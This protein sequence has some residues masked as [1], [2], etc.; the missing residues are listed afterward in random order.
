MKR[1]SLIHG[2]R[3]MGIGA[4][5]SA[6]ALLAE[7]LTLD[8][9]NGTVQTSAMITPQTSAVFNGSTVSVGEV[10]EGIQEYLVHGDFDVLNGDLVT[11]TS[12]GLGVRFRVANDV[13]IAPGGLLDFSADGPDGGPGGGD[14]S[15]GGS[16]GDGSPFILNGGDSATGGALDAASGGRAGSGRL[17]A[18]TPDGGEGDEGAA[19]AWGNAGGQG[20]V[21]FA[22]GNSHEGGFGMNAS[23]VT[24]G[25]QGGSGG[26]GGQ[27]TAII[28]APSNGG[29]GGAGG[30]GG[31]GNPLAAVGG[32]G[33]ERG[34]DGDD[35]N[36][37]SQGDLG[38]GGRPGNP[39][40]PG[41]HHYDAK[42]RF[43]LV[44]GSA[45]SGGGGGGQGGQGGGGSSGSGGSAG[46]GGGGGG[47][48]E[49][50]SLNNLHGVNGG[51]GGDG[52]QGGASGAGGHGGEGGAGGRGGVGGGGGGVIE[53]IAMGSIVID[54]DI[55]AGGGA[56]TLGEDGEG[57]HAGDPGE[58][59]QAG[60][61]GTNG[62]DGADVSPSV[63]GGGQS[64]DGHG[65][66]GDNGPSIGRG[67]GGGGGN[68]GNG[69][70]GGDGGRGGSGGKGG[71]GGSGAG[72]AG[73]T[74]SL[75]AAQVS[76]SG[77]LNTSGGSGG[78]HD[79]ALRGGAG[80]Q[81]I[82]SHTSPSQTPN[83]MGSAHSLTTAGPLVANRFLYGST[84]ETPSIPNLDGGADG[85]GLAPHV[86]I[87]ES[88]LE[89]LASGSDAAVIIRLNSTSPVASGLTLD[90]PG[91]DWVLFHNPTDA[92]IVDPEMGFDGAPSK[93]YALHLGG[94][95]NNPDFG[96]SNRPEVLE[97]LEPGAVYL[98][99][100]P[101]SVTSIAYKGNGITRYA[102]TFANND[103]LALMPSEIGLESVRLD[104]SLHLWEVDVTGLDAG[105]HYHLAECGDGSTFLPRS[106]SD[107]TAS[108][109]FE[110]LLVGI[111]ST[112]ERT[113][114]QVRQGTVADALIDFDVETGDNDEEEDA[115][116]D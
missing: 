98:T 13:N 115:R 43:M 106:G 41:E 58:A 48:G 101:E 8:P 90:Y 94:L 113:F 108:A 59:G 97:F 20:R 74:I 56:G 85:F 21:G 5:M 91:Y 69:G 93:M 46:G 112:L 19:G 116:D 89:N 80:K 76:G 77:M 53:I 7:T 45:G 18:A 29:A 102:N 27:V 4:A 44:G 100:I 107:F 52:G 14:G 6:N 16:G 103:V 54:G 36:A 61:S 40:A 10:I 57:G 2:A 105:Q 17:S 15:R 63:Q 95:A 88:L 110:T 47:A 51:A 82:G 49:N 55:R 31:K 62:F 68:G 70:R 28:P 84:S 86:S 32:D 25:A 23:V 109:S 1:L 72:G 11:S 65:K 71:R 42:E 64:K 12:S 37:G 87:S 99:L 38:A 26:A 3:I 92:P 79:A 75:I 30:Q 34:S 33:G 9:D 24:L 96:G 111:D 83:Q 67:A 81:I 50:T 39:G 22:G 60:D 73:G 78:I 114:L 35:G 104:A 66:K